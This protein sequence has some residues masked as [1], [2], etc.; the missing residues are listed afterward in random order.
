MKKRYKL[1]FFLLMFGISTMAWSRY[2]GTSGL[3]IKEY[4]IANNNIPSG[5]DGL[6]IV[7][8]T[9]IHYGRTT[10]IKELQFIVSEIN[11]LKPDLIFF[12][13][14]LLDENVKLTSKMTTDLEKTLSKLDAK[15]GKYAVNGNHDT[16][17]KNYNT[18]IKN[19]G[20]TNLNNSY[21]IIYDNKYQSIYI[22][23]LETGIMGHPNIAKAT[24][25]LNV[26]E[27]IMPSY[28]ILIMHTPDTYNKVKDYNFDL[29][30][31]G[32]SHNGQVRLPYI[33]PIYN[34]P[35]AKEYYEPY[36][37]MNNTD[38][39]ISGGLGT[40]FMDFRLFNKPAF[41]FYRLSKK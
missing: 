34:V 30:L 5:F 20:F 22:A 32:H 27:N 11:V 17:F 28:K 8:F 40:S 15:I 9:D 36:Y 1:F 37:K 23:G 3:N 13:G 21:D 10:G 18:I 6:K 16:Y 41:N 7:H 2:I 4:K 39:Y 38:L 24:A 29:V 14:D 35:G 12:T 26:K 19:S 33:G 25:Y 31:A